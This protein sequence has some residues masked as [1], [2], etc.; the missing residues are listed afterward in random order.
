MSLKRALRR[1]LGW[2][3][4]EAAGSIRKARYLL[5]AFVV[6]ALAALPA[7]KQHRRQWLPPA[8]L[9]R[10]DEPKAADE[11][12]APVLTDEVCLIPGDAP[13]VRVEDAPGN[14]RRIFT[15]VDIRA[16]V[17]DVWSVMTNY[18]QLEK[19]VPNLVHNQVLEKTDNGGAR[20]WQ[21]GRASWQILGRHF[22]FQAGTTLDVKLFPDGLP[23]DS[24]AGAHLDA[25]SLSSAE[26]RAMGKSTKLVR[27]IFPRPF[28]L[29]ASGVPVHDITMQNVKGERGD[30]VHYQGVW[31]LQ[32]LY[33][34]SE[35]G[36]DMMRLT[37]AVE[38]EP[39]W[40]LPVAPVEGR[41]ACALVENMEAIRSHVEASRESGNKEAVKGAVGSFSQGGSSSSSSSGA[42]TGA[43]PAQGGSWPTP[44]A[45]L[46]F[47]TAGPPLLSLDS[48]GAPGAA[49]AE[50]ASG[51]AAAVEE[52][53]S[54]LQEGV[55]SVAGPAHEPQA[56]SEQ[57]PRSRPAMR[58][59]A[60]TAPRPGSSGRKGSLT[61]RQAAAPRR[62]CMLD[63]AAPG[64]GRLAG[65]IEAFGKRRAATARKAVVMRAS[66]EAEQ[67]ADAMTRTLERAEAG[68]MAESAGAASGAALE[69]G[70]TAVL[71]TM[72]E[73]AASIEVETLIAASLAAGLAAAATSSLPSEQD[74]QLALKASQEETECPKSKVWLAVCKQHPKSVREGH[75]LGMSFDRGD[76]ERRWP[77]FVKMLGISEQE[78]LDIVDTDSTPL[79]VEPE[80]AAEVLNRLSAISSREKALELVSWNPSLLVAGSPAIKREEQD[81][82]QSVL[83]DV[84][85]AG[86]LYR[87]L[88][89]VGRDA[90]EKLAEIEWYSWAVTGLKPLLDVLQ[91]GALTATTSRL[92]R[93][94][95]EIAA[96]VVPNTAVRVFLSRLATVPDPWG[97]M[98]DQAKA[99]L[100]MT[101]AL[102]R[103]PSLVES[104]IPYSPSILPHLP[105]IYTRLSILRPHVPGIARILDPYFGIVEPHL[106]R[107]ME[108]MDEI[109]PHLPYIL[110]HLDVLAPHCGPLLDHFDE[111]MPY[112]SSKA[113]IGSDFD[114]W[115]VCYQEPAV[116]SEGFTECVIENWDEF[117]ER[118][119][120]EIE[121]ET[122]SENYLPRLLPY[123][124]FL[125]PNLDILAPHLRLVHPHLP[126][127]LPYIDDLLP[128]IPLFAKHPK[129]SRN[130]DVLVG[131]LGWTLRVPL[132][133]RVLHVPLV[134]RLVAELSTV[135]PR[136]FI[137]PVL[138][139]RRR[140][141]EE[142]ERLAE[143]AARMPVT[144]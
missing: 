92:C 138:E 14:A 127:I 81:P 47:A 106:D 135:L 40:F 137:R 20:L 119:D 75:F 122:S 36:D 85:Y 37:F 6:G 112:A 51:L 143:Q 48:V 105:S 8:A 108:R 97:F 144:S 62:A 69:A 70:S 73:L 45:P 33:E 50:L 68:A 100:L 80:H 25:A 77:R 104:I 93:R 136:R 28:S 66:L 34:C 52:A 118:P 121:R 59:T 5:K 141:R 107:I 65:P 35:P 123:V 22:Y 41:I 79:L 55:A 84:L 71:T 42:G 74:R 2:Y 30:F 101:N 26:A 116:S 58:A 125:V 133:P 46:A 44:P 67:L 12:N 102:V 24:I 91:K 19:V 114:S 109:E 27:D 1:L 49:L 129:A 72:A 63:A 32:P 9:G 13:V 54:F 126:H 82:R 103:R 117:L 16:S 18:E 3:M 98:V 60:P 61:S 7:A 17:E 64:Y 110:I 23:E 4:A 10:E 11:E 115:K 130:A 43:A 120:H 87:V 88:E 83:V 90:A 124:D 96:Q 76:V 95:I 39:H 56:L 131:Y 21:I 134:P 89:E 86:R 113:E 53:L 140:R 94:P 57:A 78:A 99:G 38:C 132:L 142:A 15:G 128:Y 111:L 31:R 29:S 139:R